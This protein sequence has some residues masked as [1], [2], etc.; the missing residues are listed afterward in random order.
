MIKCDVRKLLY[1]F[2]NIHQNETYRVKN[3]LSYPIN[4]ARNFARTAATTHFVF[5]CDIE[6]Y[7]NP[8]FVD[9]FFEMIVDDKDGKWMQEK[10]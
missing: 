10:K 1:K 8:N 5:A 9:Q 3:K 7:P 4:A 2:L 6:L